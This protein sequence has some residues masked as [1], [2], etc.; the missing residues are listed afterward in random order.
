MNNKK[1]K[2]SSQYH[3][4]RQRKIQALPGYL[5]VL[6]AVC[7]LML[8]ATVISAIAQRY[9]EPKV[10]FIPPAF[11]ST[12]VSGMPDVPEELKFNE[13]HQE[14][15]NYKVFICGVVKQEESKALVYF[16]N[17]EENAV[18]LK[19]RICDSQGNMLGESGLVKPGEYIPAVSLDTEVPP[20][21][22]LRIEIMSY[23]P[24]TYFSMGAV[25]VNTTVVE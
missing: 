25:M 14:G 17:P 24:D 8:A 20:D 23:E 11:D 7:T 3:N 19:I 2:I 13:L 12:A 15:M 4:H 21:T 6:G 1:K 10:E 22:P 9:R 18:W 5:L 16:T